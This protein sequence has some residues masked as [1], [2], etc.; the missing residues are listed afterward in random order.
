MLRLKTTTT[1]NKKSVKINK[2]GPKSKN[3]SQFSTVTQRL[4]AR[5]QW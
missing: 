1:I 2:T 3:N 4:G 5:G